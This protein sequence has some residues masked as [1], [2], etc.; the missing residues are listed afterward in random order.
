MPDGGIVKG[1]SAERCQESGN[2][3]KEKTYG[4]QG[5]HPATEIEDGN[6]DQEEDHVDEGRHKGAVV[7]GG[8]HPPANGDTPYAE[9]TG[10]D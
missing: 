8:P 1:A 4:G 9:R 2:E 10:A 3:K 6:E 5:R 7:P